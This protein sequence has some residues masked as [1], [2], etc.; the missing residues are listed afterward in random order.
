MQN[1]FVHPTV[2]LENPN[3]EIADLDLV[4]LKAK[5][6]QIEAGLVNSFGFG[7]QNASVLIGRVE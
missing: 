6:K 5:D 2:N 1:G 3:D 4:P 7:G